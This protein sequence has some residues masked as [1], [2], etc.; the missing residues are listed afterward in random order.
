MSFG[1]GNVI[2]R[3]FLGNI[4]EKERENSE[5]NEAE[6]YLNFAESIELVKKAQPW[7]KPAAPEAPFAADLRKAVSKKL[8]ALPN[9]FS[10]DPKNLEY[11]TAVG[12]PLD[13]FH[14]VDAFMEYLNRQAGIKT[15]ALI[16]ITIDPNKQLRPDI[17]DKIVLITV[18]GDGLAKDDKDDLSI[19]NQ[20]IDEASDE[21]IQKLLNGQKIE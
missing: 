19:W 8:A 13:H 7:E 17:I 16:D 9:N 15:R 4:E 18:P 3:E 21:I 1:Q 2:E 10:Y 11:F 14:S 20:I 6:E 12:S 5:Y